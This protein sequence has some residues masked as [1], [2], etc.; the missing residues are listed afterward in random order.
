MQLQ[1]AKL[2]RTISFKD[3]KADISSMY[4]WQMDNTL[5]A[6]SASLI[7]TLEPTVVVA[8]DVDGEPF[9]RFALS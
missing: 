6:N 5:V 9:N 2:H 8:V 4:Q 7:H 3:A 1:T